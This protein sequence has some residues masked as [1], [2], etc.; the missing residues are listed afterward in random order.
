MKALAEGVN[1]IIDEQGR[2]VQF[3][4][5]LAGNFKRLSLWIYADEKPALPKDYARW[6]RIYADMIE[7]YRTADIAHLTGEDN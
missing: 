1:E 3:D 2:R 5:T 7:K 6:L 4:C